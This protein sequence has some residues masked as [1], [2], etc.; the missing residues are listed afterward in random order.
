M[1][2]SGNEIVKL[3]KGPNSITNLQKLTSK[4]PNLDLVNIDL[5]TKFGSILSI[6]SQDIERKKKF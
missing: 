2:L 6:H 4:N 3:I 1:I 5:Y